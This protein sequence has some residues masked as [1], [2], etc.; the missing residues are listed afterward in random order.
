MGLSARQQ[1][2]A[3]ARILSPSIAFFRSNSNLI[4]SSINFRIYNAILPISLQL[5]CDLKRQNRILINKFF[6][7]FR[8]NRFRQRLL[9]RSGH[10]EFKIKRKLDSRGILFQGYRAARKKKPV[11]SDLHETGRKYMLKKPADE[12]HGID[13]LSVFGRHGIPELI[14]VFRAIGPENVTYRGHV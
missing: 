4:F 12:F 7:A 13:D 3:N 10:L 8:T 2:I 5:P 9:F 14:D 6:A 1:R 11:V